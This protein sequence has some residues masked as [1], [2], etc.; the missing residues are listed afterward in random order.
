MTDSKDF[1]WKIKNPCVDPDYTYVIQGTDK[2]GV[3]EPNLLDN[4]N[5]VVF[6][7]RL[8]YTEST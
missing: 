5:Y 1:L 2:D 7:E 4:L 6:D 3:Q 8:I